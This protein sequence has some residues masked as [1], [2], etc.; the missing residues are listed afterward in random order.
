M[1]VYNTFVVCACRT[2]KT[3]LVTSSARKARG[4]LRIG[5]RIEVWNGNSKARSITWKNRE[6]INSYVQAEKDWIGHKQ[7]IA[8]TRNSARQIART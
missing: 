8:E 3:V 6:Q 1:A 7:M 5:Q 2:G 4:E